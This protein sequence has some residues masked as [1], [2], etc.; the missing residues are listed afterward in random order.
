M[1]GLLKEGQYRLAIVAALG[2]AMG[3]W[4]AMGC[5][6]SGSSGSSSDSGTTTADTTSL[7]SVPN[8]DVS[9]YDSTASS[10]SS[11]S[12]SAG[13][14]KSVGVAK[15]ETTKSPDNKYDTR[16]EGGVSRAG[17]EANMHVREIK[18]FGE[19][20][21]LPRCYLQEMEAAGLITIPTD[22]TRKAFA[23]IEPA[24]SAEERSQR[25]SGIPTERTQEREACLAG[26]E[27]P[28]AGVVAA[29]LGIINGSLEIDVCFGKTIAEL[30]LEN[31]S[32]YTGG[33]TPSFKVIEIGKHG[34]KTERHLLTGALSGVASISDGDVTL[35]D[36]GRA[37]IT[38]KMD[39]GF[40]SGLIT[41]D[42]RK[43]FNIVQGAFNGS[44][45]DPFSGGSATSFTG[46]VYA[47][48]GKEK[49]TDT[50]I[51]GSAKFSFTG[52]VP[53][54]KLRN[55]VPF[56]VAQSTTQL[57]NF[58]KVLIAEMNLV[59]ASSQTNDQFLDDTYL[60]P[61]PNFN[62]DS[63][64]L[65]VKPMKQVAAG[66]ACDSVTHTGV[67]SFE[68]T[69]IKE[70]NVFKSR[71]GAL[72]NKFAKVTQ[73]FKVIAN[74]ASPF[75]TAVNAF[76]LSTLDPT[77]GTIAFER[78]WDC[79]NID[80][81]LDLSDA[82][83]LSADII[84]KL[85]RFEEGAIKC[86]ALEEKGRDND[87]MGGHN[88]GGQENA[89]VMENIKDEPP[90][91]GNAGGEY[92]RTSNGCVPNGQTQ[93][94]SPEKLFINTTD[95][96]S[97]KYCL[98]ADQSCTEFTVSAADV[99]GLNLILP[100]FREDSGSN[101]NN[102]ITRITYIGGPGAGVAGVS[103][104]ATNA[105]VYF[106]FAGSQGTL[107]CSESYT[108]TQP[109]F[110]KPSAPPVA[111]FPEKCKTASITDQQACEQFCRKPENKCF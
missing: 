46:K 86:S 108:I 34:G 79:K 30:A 94:S 104:K 15:A 44:F 75:F 102:K 105:T 95:T 32:I 74:T 24:V 96:N 110:D 67:E 58:L 27:G 81:T 28:G 103:K 36:D 111:Q 85:Q 73:T 14:S 93:N 82:S 68:V 9:S 72:A 64:V 83:K 65:T 77:A 21:Q 66:T 51:K 49:S 89:Q 39:G 43:L 71:L 5:G 40:G 98:P 42:F 47:Q 59:K 87:G 2:L 3:A 52:T 84:A 48:V 45:T 109:S 26:G 19:Q 54:M 12:E 63:P 76:D 18:R 69:T 101:S 70:D 16:F 61:N 99:T 92:V 33:T 37:L 88:C 57:D 10:S 31:E 60:C 91:F 90:S 35:G 20:S 13:L 100:A 4:M 53:P 50:A 11:S 62:P 56:D 41:G 55:M 7:K 97:N 107:T 6:S 17:C 22:G 23:M 29:R 106:S 80:T 78:N 8:V 38:A 1:K 25:C